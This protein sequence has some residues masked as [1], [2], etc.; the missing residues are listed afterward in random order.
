MSLSRRKFLGVLA[1]LPFVGS[2]TAKVL[3]ATPDVLAPRR[4]PKFLLLFGPRGGG[5][6]TQA[7]KLLVEHCRQNKNAL[8][9][10]MSP[11]TCMALKGGA[12]SRLCDEILPEAGV[13]F[14]SPKCDYNHRPIVWIKN[15]HGGWSMAMVVGCYRKTGAFLDLRPSFIFAPDLEENLETQFLEAA[16]SIGGRDGVFVGE[17]RPDDPDHWIYRRW[18]VDRKSGFDAQYVPVNVDTGPM[19]EGQWRKT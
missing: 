6:T 7:L 3:A 15:N 10:I 16:S 5:K 17:C 8:A 14:S 13:E 18:W 2:A 11:V 1:A 19:I 4:A 9:V 12:F